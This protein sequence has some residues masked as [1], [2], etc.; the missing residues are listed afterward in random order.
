[1]DFSGL[2]FIPELACA[3]VVFMVGSR[4]DSF[5]E[6]SWAFFGRICSMYGSKPGY[7]SRKFWRKPR[8]TED[9]TFDFVLGAILLHY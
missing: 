7:E 9:L 6:S 4:T 3:F 1:M 2:D 5:I 8:C